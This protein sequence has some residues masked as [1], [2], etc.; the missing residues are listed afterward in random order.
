[1]SGIKKALIGVVLGGSGFALSACLIGGFTSLI[2]P[3]GLAAEIASKAEAVARQ[4]GGPSGFGGEIMTGYAGRMPMHMGFHDQTA[5]ADP[6]GSLMVEM[7]NLSSQDCVFHLSYVSSPIGATE[8]TMDVSVP[9]GEVVTVQ[10]PCSEILGMGPMEMPNQPGCHLADGQPVLNTMAVPG[11]I[12]MNY[13]CGDEFE[14]RLIADLND[15]DGD[16]DRQE[17]IIFSRAMEQFMQ[18]GVP[19]GMGSMLGG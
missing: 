19:M 4:T 18:R 6:G 1:M 3:T 15:L 8:Q 9:A 5:L 16:G 12:G 13:S 7:G 2:A 17:L 10:I 14:F 11:F